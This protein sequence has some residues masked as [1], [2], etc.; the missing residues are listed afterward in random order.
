M[1]QIKNPRYSD[2]WHITSRTA[3]ASTGH[4]CTRCWRKDRNGSHET[5]HTRY[6]T[7][8]G[9]VR[10]FELRAIGWYLFPLCDPCHHGWAHD[11]KRYVIYRD[12]RGNLDPWRN[13]NSNEAIWLLWRRYWV[14]RLI[15]WR[16]FRLQVALFVG[17][18]VGTLAV[19]ILMR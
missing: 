14:L 19:C 10:D 2:R 1:N 15:Q 4:R 6:Q 5:H 18:F 11:L 7:M 3:R 8:R 12:N 13:H 9:R 16:W 17:A